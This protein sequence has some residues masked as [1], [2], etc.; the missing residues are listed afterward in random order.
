MSGVLTVSDE[1]SGEAELQPVTAGTA[2]ANGYGTFEVLA[3]GSWTYSLN[4]GHAAVQA[5]PEG[6]TLSDSLTVL[7]EDGTASQVISITIHGTNDAAVIGGVSSGTVTEDAST[8]NLTTAGLLTISDPDAG[9]SSFLTQSNIAGS[10]GYGSFSINAAGNWSYSA[11]TAQAAIQALGAGASLTDSF[12]VQSLDGSASQLVTVTIQGTNDAPL[13]NAAA[14]PIGNAVLEDAGAPVGAV[15]T[16]VS[17]L[18]NLNPP[19]GGLDN[20]TDVDSGAVTGIAITNAET[21]NGTWYYSLNGGATW[22]ALGAVS[23]SVARLL[24]ADGDNR[25]YFQPAANFDGEASITFRA[26]DQTSGSDGGTASTTSNGGATAFS[27]ATDTAVFD[28]TPV[29]DGP[30]GTAD[31]LFINGPK[32]VVVTLQNAWLT[33]ND[34]AQGGASLNVASATAG[35]NTSGVSVSATTT[36]FSFNENNTT[37][38]FTYIATD[39]SQTSQSTTVSITSTNGD[40]TG[41]TGN[42][43]LIDTRGNS[44]TTLDGGAGN[45]FI[46][47][48]VSDNI[49]IG[50]QNDRLLDGGSGADTLRVGASFASTGDAQIANI[51]SV[52]LTTATTLNLSNQTEAFTILGSSGADSITGGSGADRIIGGGGSD[53]LTGNGGADRFQLATSG[54]TSTITDYIDGVDK[55]AFLDAGNSGGGSVNF[56]GTVGTATGATLN[57]NDLVTRTSVSNIAASD[58]QKVIVIS[59]AQ[60]TN[61]LQNGTGGNGSQD[62]YVIAFNSN[63]GRGEVWFDTD[64]S[65]TAGRVKVATLDNITNLSGVTSITNTD[66]VVY[67]TTTA[68]AGIAGEPINLTLTDPEEHV[69]AVTVSINGVP[70]GWSISGGTDNGDGSWTVQTDD[71]RNLSVTTAA[72]FAGALVL[73][74]NM[75]WTNADGSTGFASLL[76]NVEAYAPGSSIFALSSDDNLTGSGGDD[77][78]VFAQP[79]AHNQIHSFDAAS[80]RI[81]LIGF[82]AGLDFADLQIANDGQGNALITL[83]EGSSITLRGVDAGAL[84]AANFVF[85]LEPETRNAGTLTLHDGSMLPLGGFLDNSGTVALDS[86]GRE[87]RLEVLADHLTLRGGGQLTLSDDEHNL[88]I[89]GASTVRLVNEDNTISGAGNLGGGQ[90][91]LSNAGTILANGVNSLQLDTGANTIVNSGVLAATG[92]GGMTVGSALDNTGHLWANGGDLRLMADVTGNGSATIDGDA[93]LTFGGAAQAAVAF[94]GEGAGTLVLAH[95]EDAASL[96]VVLGLEQDDRLVFGDLGFGAGTQLGY[97]ANAYGTGGL[98]TLDNG[99]QHA[100]L[101]LLGRYS[102]ADFQVAGAGEAG[103]LL[104]YTGSQGS[105]TLVGSMLADVLSGGDGDDILVGRGG[106][107]ALSGGAGSDVF[108][109][110]NLG[111]GVDSILDYS[112]ADGDKLDLSGLLDANFVAASSRI[113]DFV[114]LTQSGSDITVQVD[115]DGAANGTAFAPVIVLVGCATE[116]NDQVMAL[117]GG[118]GQVLNV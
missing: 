48:G 100:E 69:G 82:G 39:G 104:S 44:G 79:I 40:I 77:L 115:A 85:D 22:T 117:F 53:T 17:A 111:E 108:A 103:T 46:M 65:S 32:D 106:D 97:S 13:L 23:A 11:S 45:D 84:S 26:W 93:S 74:V 8:P 49:L 113:E 63:T 76:D 34:V 112:F 3:D 72:S 15:G 87:T 67:S 70:A 24:A 30:T 47:G 92:T 1:D 33:A 28:V 78:F 50:E 20:V 57:V 12:T 107:D 56:A 37:G 25:L 91:T 60:T 5:L 94:H 7:S 98:L 18:V 66:I 95:A 54:G 105:G 81:D 101:N 21:A 61:Q 59:A 38:S 68:P 96:A 102:A 27:T 109:Y 80:D 16:L 75:T 88:I 9:Q 36:T 29:D 14:T 86:H 51:E 19:A 118:E 43:I 116:G 99:A 90:M 71:P 114:Q 41:G 73:A 42:D 52:Q 10:N 58:D 6:V 31:T 2:G 62:N 110:R 55:I 4:N 35:T 83:G 89:G 64:W